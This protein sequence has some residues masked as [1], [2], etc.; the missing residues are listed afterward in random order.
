MDISFSGFGTEYI[1]DEVKLKFP[2]YKIA[3]IDTDIL[4]NNTQ[5]QETLDDFKNGKTDILLGTQMVAKGLNFPNV[6]LVG[7]VL[8]DTG[9]SLP[10]FRAEERVFS[11]IVQVAGRAGRFFSDGKVIVQTFN[12]HRNAIAYACTSDIEGFYSQELAQ[13]QITDFPPYSRLIRFVFRSAS[14][15]DSQKISELAFDLLDDIIKKTNVAVD[16]L[17]PAECP[18]AKVAANYRNHI[19]LKAKSILEL[20]KTTSIFLNTFK[21]SKNVY[22]EVDVDPISLL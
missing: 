11:L 3:R 14:E 9:L 13:R 15:V 2:E 20:Q 10:D 16:I 5:L 17:G 22:I 19:I 12:P 7:I 1:E 21:N 6:K 8:A 4:S 18:L